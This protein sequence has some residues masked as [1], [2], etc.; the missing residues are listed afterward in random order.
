MIIVQLCQS[1]RSCVGLTRFSQQPMTSGAKSVVEL[2][3][4]C[5]PAFFPSLH[6][7]SQASE[8]EELRDSRWIQSPPTRL[9]L[10]LI[11]FLESQTVI[12]EKV[13]VFLNIFFL[14]FSGHWFQSRVYGLRSGT[15]P[16]WTEFTTSR[17]V[18]ST[19]QTAGGRIHT[20]EFRQRRVQGGHFA[21]TEAK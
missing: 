20:R 6:R 9:N 11:H 17:H 8:L 14:S 12:Y 18:C 3:I 4:I 21:Q 1:L 2:Q 16:G 19:D 10:I 15:R 13:A 5:L 7:S